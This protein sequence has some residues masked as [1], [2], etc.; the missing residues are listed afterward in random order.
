MLENWM[1][2]YAPEELFDADGRLLSQLQELAPN[3]AQRMGAN[4]NANGG[5]LRRK[6]ELPDWR[7]YVVQVPAPGIAAQ[8][9]T[10]VAGGYLRDVIRLNA[11]S[12]HFRIVG[13]Q[14]GALLGCFVIG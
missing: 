12:R 9:A 14:F 10:Q 11:K 4:P 6:L 5:L 2:S 3:G 8:S 7:G 1:R 13:E